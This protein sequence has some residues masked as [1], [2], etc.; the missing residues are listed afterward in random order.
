MHAIGLIV[1]N[2]GGLF[3]SMALGDFTGNG[4]DSYNWW[5]VFLLIGGGIALIAYAISSEAR[6]MQEAGASWQE[7]SRYKTGT[8]AWSAIATLWFTGAMFA[9][10]SSYSSGSLISLAVWLACSIGASVWWSKTYG[11]RSRRK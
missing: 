2:L 11:S 3:L 10:G 5:F 9:G 7:V 4:L 6:K 8:A 1:L